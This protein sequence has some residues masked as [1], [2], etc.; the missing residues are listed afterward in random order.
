MDAVVEHYETMKLAE[1][2][3][4]YEIVQ[5]HGSHFCPRD[6]V[7]VEALAD[8]VLRNCCGSSAAPVLSQSVNM[9]EDKDWSDYERSDSGPSH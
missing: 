8:F 2:F 7:T 5:Y 1:S 9:C 4:S 6:C 3:S